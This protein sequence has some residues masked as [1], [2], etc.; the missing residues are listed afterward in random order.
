MKTT[1]S[2]MGGSFDHWVV[3]AAAVCL[4]SF[5]A[6]AQTDISIRTSATPTN[7]P[8]P[9]T[10][11]FSARGTP[12][13]APY[14]SA[15][16]YQWNF[17]DGSTTNGPNVKHNYLK[18]GTY[19]ATVVYRRYINVID[20]E[21]SEQAPQS[22]VVAVTAPAALGIT[23]VT[24]TFR[25]VVGRVST[26]SATV[27]ILNE[28]GSLL[29]WS[30][31]VG[32]GGWLRLDTNRGSLAA[33]QQKQLQVL[34]NNSNVTAGIYTAQLHFTSPG[35]A[36]SAVTTTVRLIQMPRR[37][38]PVTTTARPNQTPKPARHILVPILIALGLLAYATVA[39]SWRYKVNGRVIK[40]KL[41]PDPGT[42]RVNVQGSLL[43]VVSPGAGHSGRRKIHSAS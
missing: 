30:A 24:L 18:P 11:A 7:G 5:N 35:A 28:G 25:G 26:Q 12:P 10:V 31:S 38:S 29:H 6:S 9:L 19:R 39:L 20:A 33:G 40:V 22:V 42:Q 41:I 3:I 34:I 2:H 13:S 4:H 37:N 32:P 15:A 16:T 43:G 14:S 17:G 21:R 23:P 1:S 8:S 36:K 27:V